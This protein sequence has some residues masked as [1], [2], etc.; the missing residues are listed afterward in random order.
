MSRPAADGGGRTEVE[1]HVTGSNDVVDR[2]G[3]I[4]ILVTTGFLLLVGAWE[5]LILVPYVGAQH[6][7]GTDHGFFRKIGEHWLDTG[8]FY[9]PRQ[10]AGPYIVETDVD[11]LYPPTAIPFFAALRWLPFP[12]FWA[13]PLGVIAIVLIKL[14]PRMWTWPILLF[15]VVNPISPRPLSDLLYGNTNMWIVAAIGAG[16]VWG[17]PAVLVTLNPSLGPF[18]LVGIRHKS[19]WVAMA[20]LAVASLA[21][22]PLWRD[23]FTAIRNSNA[24]WYWSLQDVPLMCLPLVAWLGRQNG[25]FTTLRA[26]LKAR[27]SLPRLRASVLQ[28][29]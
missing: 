17:W 14:R 24:E 9:L 23:Y 26:A 29:R 22:L 20:I 10:L 15:L 16:I 13:I 8:Q 21:V 6:A 25:G 11:V 27:L 1:E 12:L 19:W 2:L 7:L 18:A 4:T 28:G 3:R 5:L